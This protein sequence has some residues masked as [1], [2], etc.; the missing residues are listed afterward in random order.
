MKMKWLLVGVVLSLGLHY[1]LLDPLGSDATDEPAESVPTVAMLPM[2]E[3]PEEPVEPPS[4]EPLE[5]D[6]AEPAPTELELAMEEEPP[7][8]SEPEPDPI[9]EAPAPAEVVRHVEVPVPVENEAIEPVIAPAK[10]AVTNPV[11]VPRTLQFVQQADQSLPEEPEPVAIES[12]TRAFMTLPVASEVVVNSPATVPPDAAEVSRR[13]DEMRRRAAA[14]SV[15]SNPADGDHASTQNGR[16]RPTP[17]I[18]WGGLE[19][20]R[21]VSRTGGLLLVALGADGAPAALIVESD[22]GWSRRSLPTLLNGYS[23]RVRIVDH[24][25]LFRPARSVT[26]AG[27]RLAILI[28]RALEGEIQR[29]MDEAIRSNGLQDDAVAICEGVLMPRSGRLTFLVQDI[30]LRR[31]GG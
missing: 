17:R 21:T 22:G 3:V 9:E 16:P 12:R 5:P 15:V 20:W 6:L 19:A 23:I 26:R 24:V 8:P 14:R 18:Q 29:S 28:P 30:R 4:P 7:A 11:T 27:E 31:N 25:A 2:Q 13:I 1:L 10:V